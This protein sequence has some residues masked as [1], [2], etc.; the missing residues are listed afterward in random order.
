MNSLRQGNIAFYQLT[1]RGHTFPGHRRGQVL[2]SPEGT[3]SSISIFL[4]IP[5]RIL[6]AEVNSRSIYKQGQNP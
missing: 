6:D 1:H 3:L 4:E 5:N 2:G